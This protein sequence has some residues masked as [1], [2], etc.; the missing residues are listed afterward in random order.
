MV[1][2]ETRDSVSVVMAGISPGWILTVLCARPIEKLA[3]IEAID[4]TVREEWVDLHTAQVLPPL[5]ERRL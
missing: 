3:D 4:H 1:S 5:R 2:M